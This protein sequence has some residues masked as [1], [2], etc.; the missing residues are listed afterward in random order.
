MTS[1]SFSGI[2][3]GIVPVVGLV[4]GRIF[5]KERCSIFQGT[6][7]VISIIGVALTTAGGS[8]NFSLLGTVLLICAAVSSSFFSVIS[9]QVS[10]QFTP[11]ERTYVMFALGSV[12][13]TAIA[14]IENRN[15]FHAL[16]VPL[17]TPGFWVSVLYLSAASSVGAFMLLN[18]AMNYVS[19]GTASVFSNFTTV[20][21]VLA[22]IFIMHDKFDVPQI[23]G[24]VIITLSVLGVSYQK[25]EKPAAAKSTDQ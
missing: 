10:G 16:T 9:R 1:S 21:S 24:I 20:I 15:D 2:M 14:L 13:F 25:S 3:L 17:S 23:I 19:V 6:C 12:V 11:L 22:G 8:G 4:L 7:A 18:Y 5:M